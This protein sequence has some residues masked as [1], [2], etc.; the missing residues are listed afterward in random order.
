MKK[1]VKKKITSLIVSL[2][3]NCFLIVVVFCFLIAL[4]L[5]GYICG[6]FL[7]TG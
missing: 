3:S 2:W 6:C 4:V 7:I 1:L 5:F